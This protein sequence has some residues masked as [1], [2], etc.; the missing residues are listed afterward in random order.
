M[1]LVGTSQ[2]TI[3]PTPHLID[4]FGQMASSFE[5]MGLNPLAPVT[6][7][8]WGMPLLIA[9]GTYDPGAGLPDADIADGN[10]FVNLFLAA[11][12]ISPGSELSLSVDAVP[13]PGSIALIGLGLIGL[14][15]IRRRSC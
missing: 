5:D 12:G 13:E 8:V 4:G 14:A 10:S 1:L 11:G 9:A 15:G 6:Q 2:D 3:A 7:P